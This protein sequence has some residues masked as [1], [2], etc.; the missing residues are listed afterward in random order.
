MTHCIKKINIK[1][2]KYFD[3]FAVEGLARVNLVTGKNNVGKTAFLEAVHTNTSALTLSYF[4]FCLFGIKY[5]RENINILIDKDEVD[6]RSY[7]EQNNGFNVVSDVHKTTAFNISEYNGIKKYIFDLNEQRTTVNSNDFSFSNKTLENSYFIDNFGVVNSSIIHA[8]SKMQELDQEQLLI[9]ELT[10]FDSNITD[11]KI[12][13]GKPK[14][15]INNAYLELTELGDGTQHL[16]SII[17]LLFQCKE[18]YLFIDEMDNGIHYQQ[19]DNVWQII[20][21]ISKKLKVQVF[22]TTHSKECLES[23]ARAAEQLQDKDIALI[24]LGKSDG[25]LKNIVFNY[26]QT[27]KKISQGL[28]VRGW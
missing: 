13:N 28:G 5:R 2:F 1:H 3:N 6:A 26:D 25:T 15:K 11:F 12:I 21:N 10:K 19:L 23:Y 22:A 4:Y 8:F 27:I 7:L 16:I 17:T 9:Q 14:C 24:E 18:G 20:L